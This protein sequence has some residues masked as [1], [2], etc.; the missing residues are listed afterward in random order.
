MAHFGALRHCT[1][2]DGTRAARPPNYIKAWRKFRGFT[3]EKIAPLVGM[4]RE[5][6]SKVENG[7]RPFSP[8]LLD[9]LARELKCT[10]GDL[11][12]HD[13]YE[14]DDLRA[15]CDRI[16]RARRKLAAE[17]LKSVIKETA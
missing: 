10:R 1:C 7:K 9:A 16:P 4:S 2:M 8:M 12:E 3:Q 5:N 6:L 11:L 15:L 14:P 13:P 17:L